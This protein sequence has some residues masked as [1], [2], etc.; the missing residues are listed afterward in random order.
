[1][2]TAKWH[3]WSTI[4][5]ATMLL[6]MGYG[7]SRM[8]PETAL[9]G[10]DAFN[11][12]KYAQARAIWTRLAAK[13]DSEA[14]CNLGRM[15]ET[16]AGVKQDFEAAAGYYRRAAVK[17]NPYALGNLAVLY[18][19]G[20]GVDQ[21]LVKSYVYSTLATRHYAD[22]ARNYRDA[23]LRNR[24]LVASRMTGDQ[25]ESAKEQLEKL[26]SKLVSDRR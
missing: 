14:Q 1:M 20:Q 22:W 10:L 26:S 6:L 19:T 15:Y 21:D 7:V 11:R 17:F 12:G 16:G 4:S 23:A 18:A 3:I 24:D 9:D 5:I 2:T 13:E 25:L 8:V